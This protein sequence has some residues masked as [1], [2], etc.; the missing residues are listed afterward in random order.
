MILCSH[1]PRSSSGPAIS[2]NQLPPTSRCLSW[3][4]STSRTTR[5]T[6]SSSPPTCGDVSE[7]NV[8]KIDVTRPWRDGGRDAV[9]EY[10]LGPHADPVAVEFALEAKCY[11]PTKSVGITRDKPPHLA[12]PAPPIRRPGHHLVPPRPGLQRNPR[13]RAPGS[14]PGRPRRDR[15]TESQ[16]TGQ[17]HGHPTAPERYLPSSRVKSLCRLTA[18]VTATAAANGKRQR[19]ATAHNSRTIRANCGYV[20]PEKR[21]VVRQRRT[22]DNL[23]YALRR[24]APEMPPNGH[25]QPTIG[26]STHLRT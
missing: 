6:L 11:A 7:S 23:A 20:R 15:K 26:T 17:H 22:T 8:D 4:I 5:M 24:R 12:A 21:K 14:H 2:S 3:Y 18:T 13:R 10:L 16:R 9:G 1:R 25:Q 19:P